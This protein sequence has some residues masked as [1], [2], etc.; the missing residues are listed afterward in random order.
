MPK[1]VKARDPQDKR[2]EGA[3]RK[4]ARSQHA[5]ADWIWHA[6]MVV[7]SWAGKTPDQIA[8]ELAAVTGSIETTLEDEHADRQYALEVAAGRLFRLAERIRRAVLAA[9]C[10]AAGGVTHVQGIGLRPDGPHSD[11]Y[12]TLVADVFTEAVRVLN[13]ATRS[14][15]GLTYPA[16]AYAVAGHLA[17]GTFGFGQLITQLIGFLGR[18]LAA[19]RLGHDTGRSP[20][21]AVDEAH[22]I[23]VTARGDARALAASLT[24][25]QN[26]LSPLHQTGGGEDR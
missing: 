20:V 8:A 11:R 23:A 18:E 9:E 16:T 22:R 24:G 12:T 7:E 14:D 19:G 2:E 6:R 15:T 26:A 1:H 13:H 25:L 17:T 3:V 21:R 10:G 4:L 5:P